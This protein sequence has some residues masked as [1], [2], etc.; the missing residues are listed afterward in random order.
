MHK[1]FPLMILTFQLPVSAAV[2]ENGNAD[3][4]SRRTAEEIEQIAQL[5]GMAKSSD[6]LLDKLFVLWEY[7][8]ALRERALAEQVLERAEDPD[9]KSL[10]RMVRDGHQLGMDIMRPIAIELGLQLPSAPT[11]LEHVA[12]E[13]TRGM[14]PQQLELHFLRRQR[15]MHAWDIT[16]FEEY[17]HAAVNPQLRKYV[18]A[19]RA[20]LKAHAKDVIRVARKRGLKGDLATIAP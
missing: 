14:T 11:P 6:L 1:L 2:S 17:A 9:V 12:I 18:E 15:A 19:T 20:P 5:D 10:A 4:T 8:G 16:M 3:A 7:A 13:A